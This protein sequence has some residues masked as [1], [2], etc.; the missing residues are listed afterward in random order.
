MPE[1]PRI[2]IPKLLSSSY[3]FAQR[4]QP[5]EKPRP[6][7][8]AVHGNGNKNWKATEVNNEQRTVM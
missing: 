2:W 7:S 4:K 3:V 5:N 8:Q 1:K 6:P